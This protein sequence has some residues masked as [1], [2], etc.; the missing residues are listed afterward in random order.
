MCSYKGAEFLVAA[1]LSLA[2]HLCSVAAEG[3]PYDVLVD[4]DGRIVR[5]QVKSTARSRAGN[6]PN[7]MDRYEFE[8]LRSGGKAGKDQRIKSR[9]IS[10]VDVFALVAVDL[11]LVIYRSA[12]DV[13]RNI[14]IRA[15]KFTKEAQDASRDSV[16]GRFSEQ[17]SVGREA[18]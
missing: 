15:P 13:P 9:Y 3:L 10:G 11:R 8:V 4:M 16:L 18:L 5:V 12:V 1:D 7:A 14:R 6:T 2:G 17:D